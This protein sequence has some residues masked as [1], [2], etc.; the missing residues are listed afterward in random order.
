MGYVLK[1]MGVTVLPT[2]PFKVIRT[3][4]HAKNFQKTFEQVGRYVS[5]K[6]I[7]VPKTKVHKIQATEKNPLYIDLTTRRG[8]L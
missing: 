7:L 6:P 1:E 4:Q 8:D 3:K 2:G 5:I